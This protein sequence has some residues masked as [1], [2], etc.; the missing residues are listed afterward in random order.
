[1]EGEGEPYPGQDLDEVRLG[2]HVE[3]VLH[4]LGE[5]VLAQRGRGWRRTKGICQCMPD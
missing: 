5:S 3:D 2:R 1:M 4:S